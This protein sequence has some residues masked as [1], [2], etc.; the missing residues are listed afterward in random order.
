MMKGNKKNLTAPESKEFIMANKTVCD[1]WNEFEDKR[2][3]ALMDAAIEREIDDLE[4]D[5]YSVINVLSM[6]SRLRT[7][8]IFKDT[9]TGLSSCSRA[10]LNSII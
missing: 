9:T 8:R 10:I 4:Y 5:I 1:L 7:S 3:A 6:I 2:N